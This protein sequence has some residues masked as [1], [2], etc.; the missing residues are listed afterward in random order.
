MSVRR[1][2]RERKEYIYRRSLKGQAAAEYEKKRAIKKSLE[3]GVPIPTE[4]RDV[5]VSLANDLRFD[6]VT[7]FQAPNEIDD[8]YADAGDTYTMLFPQI[9]IFL[10]V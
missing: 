9:I 1:N 2:V 3:L 4:L 10:I 6:D 5:A 8:E 7:T